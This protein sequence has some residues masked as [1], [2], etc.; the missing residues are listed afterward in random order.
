MINIAA[1]FSSKF[2]MP[3]AAQSITHAL[4]D[5]ASQLLKAVACREGVDGAQSWDSWFDSPNVSADFMAKREQGGEQKRG[6]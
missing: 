2:F 1:I 4:D 5:Q 6:A 3:I